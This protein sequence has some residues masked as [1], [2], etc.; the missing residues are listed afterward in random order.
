[1]KK[2]LIKDIKWITSVLISNSFSITQNSPIVIGDIITWQGYSSISYMLKRI[3]YKDIFDQCFKK[4][5]FNIQMHDGALIQMM[6]VVNKRKIVEHRLLFLP[7]PPNKDIDQFE[8][9]EYDESNQNENILESPEMR[10][11]IRFDYSINPQSDH[12]PCHA[13]FGNIQDCRIPVE[14]PITPKRFI[15]FILKNFY[16]QEFK[17]KFDSNSF[18]C[19]IKVDDNISELDSKTLH[20]K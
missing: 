1:M 18:A 16:T 2:D 5:D 20:F 14:K 6:F 7:P 10:F 11:P 4:K 17:K 12:P 8:F 9:E 3:P 15:D 13:T 19:N